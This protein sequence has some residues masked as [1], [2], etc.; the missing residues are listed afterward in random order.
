MEPGNVL[1]DKPA[2]SLKAR[3]SEA[4]VAEPDLPGGSTDE[5]ADEL[6]DFWALGE[7]GMV[8]ELRAARARG[9]GGPLSGQEAELVAELRAARE[10]ARQ[11]R[12][13]MTK[14]QPSSERWFWLL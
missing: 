4:A 6:S 1:F 2:A 11:E 7:L 12:A 14:S 13:S 9:D 5:G 10:L 8:E 3:P